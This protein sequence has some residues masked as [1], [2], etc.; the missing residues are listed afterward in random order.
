MFL[1]NE[2]SL[3]VRNGSLGSV[4]GASAHRLEVRLDDGRA[5]AFDLKDY[6]DFDHG[7]ATTVH[8]SQGATVDY[9][10]VLASPFMDRHAAY[11]AL[12]RHRRAV[13]LHYAR[14]DF[15]DWGGLVR[16]LSRE[17]A[18]DTT[19]DYMPPDRDLR[20]GPNAGPEPM[21]DANPFRRSPAEAEREPSRGRERER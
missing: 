15:P 13:S 8:K 19:L 3:G 20:G 18:K 4:V 1:R 21:R 10:H 6:A 12:S 5:V 7:F 11:V 16:A 2:R 14:D 17:R 9:A